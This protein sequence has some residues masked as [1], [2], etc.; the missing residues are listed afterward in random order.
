MKEHFG[1]RKLRTN[2]TMFSIIL[3]RMILTINRPRKLYI[4]IVN[5]SISKNWDE[6]LAATWNSSN[7]QGNNLCRFGKIVH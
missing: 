7:E 3:D 4:E 6:K 2:C 5:N 1:G